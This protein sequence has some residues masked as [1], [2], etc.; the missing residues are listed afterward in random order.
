MRSK[1]QQ[2]DRTRLLRHDF[3]IIRAETAKIIQRRS[4]FLTVLIGLPLLI[5]AFLGWAAGL[6]DD[7]SRALGI[8][9]AFLLGLSAFNLTQRRIAYHR[10]HGAL[11]GFAQNIGGRALLSF[12]ITLSCGF[13]LLGLFLASS[14]VGIDCLIAAFFGIVVGAIS[15]KLHQ[16]VHR[17]LLARCLPLLRRRGA[18]Q[19]SLWLLTATAWIA[20]LGCGLVFHGDALGTAILCLLGLAAYAFLARVDFDT[21]VFMR[22]TGIASR[23]MIARYLK[24]VTVVLLSLT[25]GLLSAWDLRNAALAIAILLLIAMITVMHVLAYQCFGKRMAG[26]FLAI[27]AAVVSLVAFTFPPI[28]PLVLLSGIV[29]LARNA[30]SHKWLIE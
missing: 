25:F 13:V 30:A 14:A 24:S 8:I 15:P 17:R 5:M 7:A 26:W 11:S 19:A 1:F 29:V 21:V 10:R 28:A 23:H 27:F 22:L 12:A 9:L 20:G 6:P 3:A 16:I 4:D 2:K 18:K